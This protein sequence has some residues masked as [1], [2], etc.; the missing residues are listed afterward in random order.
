[1]TE[2][3]FLIDL[4]LNGRLQRTVQE[5]VKAR[6]SEVEANMSLP[7]A[8]KQFQ[9]VQASLEAPI[10]IAQ[11]PE[12]AKAL[13]DRQAAIQGSINQHP[14]EVKYPGGSKGPRKY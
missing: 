1:M 5:K 2:L 10:S 11:T 9:R 12:A 8:V 13:A 14:D 4:L 3:S 7:Q 6:I